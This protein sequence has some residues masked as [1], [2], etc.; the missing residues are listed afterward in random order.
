MPDK[1]NER[2]EEEARESLVATDLSAKMK[3]WRD[4]PPPGAALRG[5]PGLLLLL[6]LLIGAGAAWWLWPEAGAGQNLP[7]RQQPA[8][9][10]LP[11]P[12]PP[13]TAPAPARQEPVAEKP[14]PAASR[15]LALA[16]SS[17]RAPDFSSE[18]RGDAPS[19]QDA[20]NAARRALAEGR[21]ADAQQ[22][23]Q[24]VGPEYGSDAA[25]LRGHALFGLKKYARAAAVFGRLTGS[26][27]YGEAAQW[28]E[29]LALLP[30][31]GRNKTV[32]INRLK[33]IA[34]DEGHTFQAEAKRL[35]DMVEK[36]L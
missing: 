13:P 34:D 4:Q 31:F 12:E 11:A 24:N 1:T 25:Y 9:S 2:L 23:L 3:Q 15:Y 18:I 30:D 5:N 32:I 33:N 14:A 6:L 17:Y 7:P 8:Q 22:A 19:G 29:T 21:Y 10:P 26:V 36:G 35:L 16:Q 20:L 27:R 28:Y